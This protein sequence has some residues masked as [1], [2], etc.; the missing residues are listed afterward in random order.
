MAVPCAKPRLRPA[1]DLSKRLANLEAA[2]RVSRAA[3]AASASALA[4][5]ISFADFVG[6]VSAVS[7]FERSILRTVGLRSN[8][9]FGFVTGGFTGSGFVSIG[10]VSTFWTGGGSGFGSGGFTGVGFGLASVS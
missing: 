7:V 3:L 9:S 5:A 1:T 8:V 6:F 4:F 2:S 10:L